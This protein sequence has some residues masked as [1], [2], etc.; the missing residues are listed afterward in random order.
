MG[1]VAGTGW[2]YMLRDLHFPASG[3]MLDGAL[4]L[5]QLAG[6]ASQPLSRMLVAW[7]PAGLALG[8]TLVGLTRIPRMV[9]VALVIP[10]SALLLLVA[11]AVSD[12]ITQNN[13]VNQHIS[14]S[15]TR[16]GIWLAV[17]LLALGTLI[18]PPWWARRSGAAAGASRQ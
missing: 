17:G 9:R 10:S 8:V 4:P 1:V 15:F 14:S 18:A 3:P 6:G 2:L 7:L 11:N 5:Q 13:A 12:A 16:S